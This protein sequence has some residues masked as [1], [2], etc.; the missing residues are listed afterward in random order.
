MFMGMN[1]R[2]AIGVASLISV[3]SA[4]AGG[5]TAGSPPGAAAPNAAGRITSII[6][7]SE[8]AAVGVASIYEVIEGLRPSMLRSRGRLE[9]Q[10]GI[11][12]ADSGA[13]S[14][15]IKVYVDGKWI[16]DPTRLWSIPAAIVDQVQYLTSSDATT[17]FGTG[18]DAGAILVTSKIEYRG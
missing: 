13:P 12:P 1:Q 10:I 2:L 16:G 18:H 4:C 15:T 8:I 14:R 5:A 9:H 7:H 3:F 6:T 11:T 17:R